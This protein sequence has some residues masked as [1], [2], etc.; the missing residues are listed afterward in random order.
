MEL[1]ASWRWV[2]GMGVTLSWTMVANGGIRLRDQPTNK[3]RNTLKIMGVGI[4]ERVEV[5]GD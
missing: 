3:Q 4:G 5:S 1:I 2:E